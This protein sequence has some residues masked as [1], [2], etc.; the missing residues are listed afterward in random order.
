VLASSEDAGLCLVADSRHRAVYMFNH[1]EYDTETLC[2][3][4]LRDRLAGRPIALPKAYFPG[5]DPGRAPANVWRPY[6][7]LLFANWL[8]EIDRSARPL[9]RDEPVIQWALAPSGSPSSG[10]GLAEGAGPA[11]LLIAAAIGPDILPAALRILANAG[12]APSAVKV[13]QQPE[14]GRLIE[15][16]LERLEPQRIERIAQ[17]LCVLPP[18][19]KVAFRVAG[20]GGWLVARHANAGAARSVAA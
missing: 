19:S 4:Y 7:H 17:R 16:R 18:V 1:L 11:D 15:L 13:H 3:E 20:A 6:G 2:E 10:P 14:S 12:L 9:L 5:D 8:G